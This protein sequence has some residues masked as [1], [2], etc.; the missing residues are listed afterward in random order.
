[1]INRYHWTILA[2]LLL[3]T[4]AV[5]PIMIS[6]A[7]QGGSVDLH[8]N[9]IAGGGNTSNGAGSTQVSGTSGQ[10]AAGSQSS[11]G[12]IQVKSGFWHAAAAPV[13]TPSPLAGPGTFAFSAPTFTVNEDCTEA[14]I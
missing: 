8:R 3:A 11:G 2:L 5:T 12:S 6:R 7:Q 13:A 4:G 1:S 14:T 9:V 10:A